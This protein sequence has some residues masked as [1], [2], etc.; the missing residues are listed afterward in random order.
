M[1]IARPDN[2][3][4]DHSLQVEQL[5]LHIRGRVS[6]GEI[7]QVHH[8]VRDLVARGVELLG[9]VEVHRAEEGRDLPKNTRLVVVDDAEAR[10]LRALPIERGRREVDRVLDGASLEEADDLVGGH[11]RAVVFRLFSRRAEVRDADELLVALHDLVGEVAHVLPFVAGSEDLGESGAVHN[12]CAREV[13][14]GARGLH[15]TQ[16]L[17]SDDV[18]GDSLDVR[19]VDRDE[20]RRGEGIGEGG[21]LLHLGGEAPGGVNGNLGVEADHIHAQSERRLRNHRA[22]V[23]KAEHRKGLPLNLNT[24]EELLVFLDARVDCLVVRLLLDDHVVDMVDALDDTAGGK[25]EA[26]QHQLLDRVGVG[27]RRVEHRDAPLGHLVDGDVVRPRA[28]AR[29]GADGAGDFLRLE[30][31]RAEEHRV[32]LIDHAGGH[33]A[34]GAGEHERGAGESAEA[35]RADRVERLDLE[36]GPAAAARHV[37]GGRFRLRHLAL[38]RLLEEDLEQRDVV[39]GGGERAPHALVGG[40]EE[41]A[42]AQPRGAGEDRR[43]V[44]GQHRVEA[45]ARC[46]K[47]V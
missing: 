2:A 34:G 38:L 33:G 45:R 46:R 16:D 26:A 12:L 21:H 13:E 32:R 30:L 42:R 25:E 41:R 9:N 24:R 35:R 27:A 40:G 31:V 18:V 3:R 8:V 6:F 17:L 43:R 7:L 19:H 47:W 44:E 5:L 23:A 11:A 20:V 14:D 36:L 29:D 37:G 15:L 10:V 1:D 28:A 4:G 22:N 39:G